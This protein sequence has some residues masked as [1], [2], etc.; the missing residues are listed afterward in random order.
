LSLIT[1]TPFFTS[2][3]FAS[4]ANGQ[5]VFRVSSVSRLGQQN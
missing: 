4:D 5:R 1:R 3:I 2:Q